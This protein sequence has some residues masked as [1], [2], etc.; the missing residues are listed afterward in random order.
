[1]IRRLRIS[2]AVALALA[3]G[4]L[5]PAVRGDGLF[6]HLW[7]HSGPPTLVDVARIIDKIQENILDQGTVV[8][9]QPDVWSQARMTRFRQEFEDT[10]SP[11]LTKFQ[12]YLNGRIA[13]SD[14]ASFSSQT[15]LGA[16]LSP[17][18]PAALGPLTTT[19][20]LKAERTEAMGLIV[21]GGEQKT[22][23]FPDATKS[24]TA[25]NFTLLNNVFA[26]TDSGAAQPTAIPFGLEPT[27]TLDQRANYITHLHRLRRV[28][29]GDDNADS[30]GYGLYLV[31]VPVSIWPGEKTVRGFGAEVNLTVRHDFGPRFLQSTYRNLVI[32][33]LI[34]QLAPVVH[35]LARTG[36]AQKFFDIVAELEQEKRK[37]EGA[38]AAKEGAGGGGQLPALPTSDAPTFSSLAAERSFVQQAR[39][40]TRVGV[41]N[42]AADRALD[43]LNAQINLLS[44]VLS[45]SLNSLSASLPANRSGQRIYA[46]APGDVPRVFL[47][48]NLAFLGY[49]ALR[50]VGLAHDPSHV[51]PS[52]GID[53]E[54][55]R[56]IDVR[57]F[58]RHELESA[59]DL[60]EGRAGQELPVLQDVM[61][62]D[63]IAEQVYSR[64][65]EGPKGL[66]PD[67]PDELNEFTTLYESLAGRLPGNLKNRSI[68]ALCWGI[69]VQAGLLNRQLIEDMKQVKGADGYTPPLEVGAMHFYAPD[70]GAEVEMIFQE[71]VKARWPM[72]VFALE[73]V[74]DQQNIE[75]AFTRRR[76]LQLA[77]AFALSSG[78]ISFRQAINFTRQLQYEA[79]TIALNQTVSAYAHGND[80]FG[81]RF[82]PRYQT[83]PEESNL[84]AVTNLL[85]RGG[86]GPNYQLAKSK[87]E[88]GLRELTAVI[89]MPSFVRGVRIDSANNWFRLHDPDERTVR[90]AR[91]VELG[92][93]INEARDALEVACKVGRYRP[94]DVERLRVKLHQLEAML[95]LQSAYVK[96][97]YE[98]T[99]GGFA[100]FTQGATALVPQLSGFESIDFID[101]SKSLDMVVYGKNFNIYE[102]A[103]MVGGRALPREGTEMVVARDANGRP[104]TY[105]N[106]LS[107]LKA[108]NGDLILTRS[109]GSTINVKDMGSFQIMSRE[110]MRLRIPP[111]VE[112]SYRRAALTG[113]DEPG[114]VEVYV[115]TPNGISNRLQIPI[116]QKP[117]PKPAD[118]V[119]VREQSSSAYTIVDADLSVVVAGPV[120]G[121]NIANNTVP[122]LPPGK[123]V[124]ILPDPPASPPEEATVRFQFVLNDRSVVDEVAVAG[125]KRVNGVLTLT[126]TQLHKLVKDLIAKLKENNVTVAATT[127]FTSRRVTVQAKGSDLIQPTA[128]QLRISFEV[129]LS[130]TPAAPPPGAAV[131]GGP[132]D[133][134]VPPL[135]RPATVRASFDAPPRSEPNPLGVT[136][137]RAEPAEEHSPLLRRVQ[138]N[139]ATPQAPTVPTAPRPE[140][141]RRRR[142]LPPT[143]GRQRPR[144]SPPDRR[145]RP[146]SSSP[147]PPRAS[148]SRYRSRTSRSNTGYSIATP[149]RGP[150]S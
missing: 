123:V 50:S 18:T 148:T 22:V 55:V 28:N 83:P 74:V 103:V 51:R 3:V 100:L 68:G 19:D 150:R 7:G 5:T 106:T 137:D 115:S 13:R 130:E 80:N 24:T 31:R 9:K 45:D 84:R 94:E 62:I 79:Q 36:T 52:V 129:L 76:D 1:M 27:V 133:S 53:T 99:L 88:P 57:N 97:P 25:A 38:L 20:Q 119:V 122:P 37:Y 104:I 95:P 98:N 109:D 139:G 125:V 77:I 48:E 41:K 120:T 128:N 149:R 131:A 46:V 112:P 54:K 96:M 116:K 111:G 82:M 90:S 40:Q 124:R 141:S 23:N 15:A 93:R 87:I 39:T 44:N 6:D 30:A 132:A 91:S 110:V 35:E 92:R 59:Y 67:S 29:L 78:R 2:A 142:R 43:E 71:Y 121:G 89:V 127:L 47:K 16:A 11:E 21:S 85:L 4:S 107:P 10:M 117:E 102:T 143:T 86:P 138:L 146:C 101:P 75:D 145:A 61:Y 144:S 126:S 17:A 56:M 70:P 63:N 8:V 49:A 32:N 114:V 14:A 134:M 65:Y 136:F 69:A 64:R 72:I 12:T 113:R 42:E 108:P 66:T 58:L 105:L 73:P 34:D 140:R 33:D 135:A 118:P 147:S 81:W 26:K 60:M